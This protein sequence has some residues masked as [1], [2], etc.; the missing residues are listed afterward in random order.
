MFASGL[1]PLPHFIYD[2]HCAHTGLEIFYNNQL[3]EPN[4]EGFKIC[5]YKFSISRLSMPNFFSSHCLLVNISR[6]S[7]SSLTLGSKH[8]I[9]IINARSE[10]LKTVLFWVNYWA[11]YG[12]QAKSLKSSRHTKPSERG[13]SLRLKLILSRRVPSIR[14]RTAAGQGPKF[15]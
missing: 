15:I 12:R 2:I 1:F 4:V 13:E 5:V 3:Y 8:S 10:L 9:L 7:L 14:R 11:A 6:F